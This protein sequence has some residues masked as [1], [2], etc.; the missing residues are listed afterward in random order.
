MTAAKSQV[1]WTPAFVLIC[2]AQ[3]FGSAQHALLQ[4]AFSLYIIALGG[5]PFQVGLLQ[6]FGF[7]SMYLAAR[8]FAAS[9]SMI[10]AAKLCPAEVEEKNCE[11]DSPN[12]LET[13]CPLRLHFPQPCSCDVI[14]V[15]S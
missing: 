1:L 6:W 5:T 3:F 7:F 13:V 4:P 2:G 11:R 9:G 8:T 12:G 15:E 10:T 14:V